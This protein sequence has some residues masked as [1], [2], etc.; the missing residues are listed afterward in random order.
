M[1]KCGG[2][3]HS[4]KQAQKVVT[5]TRVVNHPP[6]FKTHGDGTRSCI[7]PGGQGTQIVAEKP[8]CKD[9]RGE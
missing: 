7:D 2:C 3:G 9:C 5:A 8:L 6:R 1:V 4:V